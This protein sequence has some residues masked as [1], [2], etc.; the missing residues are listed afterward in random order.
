MIVTGVKNLT[1]KPRPNFLSICD[2]DVKNIEIFTVGGVGAGFNRLWVMVDVEICR[3]ADKGAL[4]DGFRSFP[5]GFSTGQYLVTKRRG[6]ALLNM[7]KVAFAGLWYLS[8]FLCDRFGVILPRL[9]YFGPQRNIPLVHSDESND[10]ILSNALEPRVESASLPREEQGAFS[11][12]LL[13][14]PYVP[15]GLAIF[16]AGTRYFDFKNHGF[17]VLAGAA[18][19][20]V[21]AWIGF[22]IFSHR[23][24]CPRL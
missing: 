12:Y 13:L 15:L 2:P 19:G 11:V 7:V 1:G 24:E 22:E 10:P 18:V 16:I 21:T 14:L 3:Q 20:S 23:L 8:L 6:L 17:D 5:S 4:R 9:T